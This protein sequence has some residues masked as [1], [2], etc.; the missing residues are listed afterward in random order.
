LQTIFDLAPVKTYHSL[1]F[2]P[3]NAGEFAQTLR[4]VCAAG[5]PCLEAL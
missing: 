4:L 3:G 5:Q 2:L 1:D